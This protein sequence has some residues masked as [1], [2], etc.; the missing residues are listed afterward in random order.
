MSTSNQTLLAR[1]ARFR[2]PLGFVAGILAVWFARPTVR[3]LSMGAA[4]AFAGE[5]LR[6]WA[7]G[8]L[9]KSREVT[10]SGPYRWFAHPLYVG[11]SILGLGMAVAANSLWVALLLATYLGATITIAIKAEEAFLAQRFGNE[12]TTYR[13]GS[14]AAESGAGRRFAVAQ[15]IANREYRAMAGVILILL[16]LLLKL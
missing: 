9:H 3:S 4:I 10:R 11:S 7:A 8:H 1:A 2:V 5:A 13:Q 6:I 15:V 12:Y 14:D 16:V